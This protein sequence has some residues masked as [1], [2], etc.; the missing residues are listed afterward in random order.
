MLIGIRVNKRKTGT[1]LLMSGSEKA[2]REPHKTGGN[3]E[4]LP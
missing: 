3:A 4:R 1:A 2:K